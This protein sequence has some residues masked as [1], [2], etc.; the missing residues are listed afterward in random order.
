MQFAVLIGHDL[1][2]IICVV[3]F[4]VVRLSSILSTAAQAD[5]VWCTQEHRAQQ[6]RPRP[7]LHVT[8]TP[9]LRKQWPGAGRATVNT[10]TFGL[11]PLLLTLTWLV[12]GCYLN[13]LGC[14]HL[15]YSQHRAMAE[16]GWSDPSQGNLTVAATRTNSPV[17]QQWHSRNV[18][19]RTPE[20]VQSGTDGRLLQCH[21]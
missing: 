1:S 6:A 20:S 2:K 15:F 19:Y 3:A 16:K 17:T 18:S 11:L 4:C 9:S 7:P 13:T 10:A 5:R 21:L 14:P 8:L 12:Y